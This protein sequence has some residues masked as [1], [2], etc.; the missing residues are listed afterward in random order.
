MNI[1]IGYLQIF[2]FKSNITNVYLTYSNFFLLF[3][4]LRPIGFRALHYVGIVFYHTNLN[5][6]DAS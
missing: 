1:I 3:L 5:F 2:F 6:T 4:F